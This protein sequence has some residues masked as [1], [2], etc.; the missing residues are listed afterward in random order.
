M[1]KEISKEKIRGYALKNAIEHDGK[2]QVGSVISGLF[3]EGLKKENVK[4]IISDINKILKEVNALSLEKQKDEY[5]KLEDVISHRDVREE[6]ELP[7]LENVHGK[8]IMRIAPY[9]SGPLHIGNTRQLVL[10]DEYVKKYGGKLLLVMDDTIGSEEKQI[11]PEAYKLI[12]EGAKWLGVNFS[13]IFYK[14]DRLEIYYKYAEEI[15][16]KDKAYVCS[17]KPEV[18]RENRA[19]GKDC[20]CRKQSVEQNL[21]LWK[22]M[23]KVKEGSMTLRIKTS[24]QDK[25]PAFRDRVIFRIS[26]RE[27]PRIKKKYRIWPLLDFSWAVDDYLLGMTH[28]LRGKDLMIET[29]M[30][31]YIFDIFKWK[32]PEFI[33][34]G[35]LQIEGIKLSKSKGQKEIKEGKYSGWD[36]PRTWSLQSLERRG[37]QPEAIR[38]FIISQGLT[39]SETTIPIDILYSINNE[40]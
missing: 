40:V 2:A 39:K 13:E 15:I 38:K 27:H 33:H 9:P 6:G 11:I 21:K 18:L 31:E 34:T 14:S 23:F 19:K 17:C 8:V 4:D 28:V 24:M 1:P 22:E 16:K 5:E 7:E 32:K 25:D 3:S 35:L 36:D 26:E 29:K 37:I 20:S 30:E 10:N 12:E